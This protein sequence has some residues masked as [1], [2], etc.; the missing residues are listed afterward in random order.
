MS[1]FVA[2]TFFCEYFPFPSLMLCL[3]IYTNKGIHGSV[4][5]GV[6]VS[7]WLAKCTEHISS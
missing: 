4:C 6:E 3:I 5:L 2:I 7:A 1:S